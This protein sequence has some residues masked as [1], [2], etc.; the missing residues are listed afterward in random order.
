MMQ[1]ANL[2]MGPSSW[3]RIV[4]KKGKVNTIIQTST[5]HTTSTY[6]NLRK[7]WYGE[8]R[9]LCGIVKRISS[10][11]S[12]PVSGRCTKSNY[13]KAHN[14]VQSAKDEHGDGDG[15]GRTAKLVDSV[16]IATPHLG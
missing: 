3:D 7:S 9:A 1:L 6:P 12:L 14:G 10:L 15:D 4:L 13:G 11:G 2:I 16:Y 5:S 8:V